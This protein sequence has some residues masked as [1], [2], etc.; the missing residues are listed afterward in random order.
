MKMHAKMST[1]L[2]QKEGEQ[3]PGSSSCCMFSTHLQ[4]RED[5]GGCWLINV[6][7][8]RW[9]MLELSAPCWFP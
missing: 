1:A 7:V 2:K 5:E 9:C 8:S 3:I 6:I 4:Q